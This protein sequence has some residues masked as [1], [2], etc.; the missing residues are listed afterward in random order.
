MSD[1]DLTAG[2]ET[3]SA[4]VWRLA[5]GELRREEAALIVEEPLEIVVDGEVYSVVMRTPGDDLGLAAGFCLA[6][7]LIESR[8]QLGSIQACERENA[9]QVS[10]VR[11]GEQLPRLRPVRH[12]IAS[13]CG[14]CG[15]DMIEEVV[16]RL[17]PLGADCRF[18][19]TDLLA[20][21]ERL[22]DSQQHF[23]PTGGTHAAGLF[24]E[25]AALLSAAEDVGRHNALDKAIGRLLLADRL[26]EARLAF[27]SGRCSFEMVQKAARAGIPVVASV[28]APTELAVDLARRAGLTLVGFVRRETLTV[29]LDRGRV[30]ELQ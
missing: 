2:R 10:V 26:G 23:R 29:Y 3:T 28:S 17:P 16:K 20:M 18:T 12:T 11:A 15:R 14:L 1:P 27:L 21:G 9:N 24:D 13:S 22:Q 4:R 30:A 7:G 8:A 19:L 6:E 25:R 5:G